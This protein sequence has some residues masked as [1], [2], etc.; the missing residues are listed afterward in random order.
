[1]WLPKALLEIAVREV[2]IRANSFNVIQVPASSEI[3]DFNPM[4]FESHTGDAFRAVDALRKRIRR[5]II[6]YNI[7]N[8]VP[9]DV[10]KQFGIFK[11]GFFLCEMP[12]KLIDLD[13]A[14]QHIFPGEIVIGNQFPDTLEMIEQEFASES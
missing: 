10:L 11:K 12:V 6:Y 13:G 5:N 14:T 9:V 1:M 2:R 3:A 7:L 4:R 8:H